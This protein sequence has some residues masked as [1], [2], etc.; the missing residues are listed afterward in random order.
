MEKAEADPASLVKKMFWSP[1]PSP[2]SA[3][4]ACWPAS[5]GDVESAMRRKELG[6]AVTIDVVMLVV[7]KS[8][9]VTASPTAVLTVVTAGAEEVTSTVLAI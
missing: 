8:V 7:V 2:S 3:T 9:T 6:H 4:N 5:P 1:K